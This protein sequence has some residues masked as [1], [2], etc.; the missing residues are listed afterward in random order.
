M[1]KIMAHGQAQKSENGAKSEKQLS[2]SFE[3][4]SQQ[5][6]QGVAGKSFERKKFL[7]STIKKFSAP[8]RIMNSVPTVTAHGQGGNFVVSKID[9]MG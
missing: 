2:S 7:R 6:A 1:A 8:T 9:E 5:M 4:A 3:I